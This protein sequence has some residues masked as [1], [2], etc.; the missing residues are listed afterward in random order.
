MWTA[1][2]SRVLQ[3]DPSAITSNQITPYDNVYCAVNGYPQIDP[4]LITDRRPH[5]RSEENRWLENTLK[6]TIVNGIQAGL[7]KSGRSVHSV[8]SA[9][10]PKLKKEYNDILKKYK[11]NSRNTARCHGRC[12]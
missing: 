3:I 10:I 2:F 4:G 12:K 7:T 9:D 5:F 1:F 8:D 6:S 11:K